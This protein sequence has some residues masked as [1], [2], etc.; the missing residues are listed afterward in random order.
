MAYGRMNSY[1]GVGRRG[2]GTG[3]TAASVM[4]DM[5][6]SS[7]VGRGGPAAATSSPLMMVG[8]RA[9]AR[10]ERRLGR[11]AAAL[12]K[13]AARATRGKMISRGI[14][15]GAVGLGLLGTIRNRSGPGADKMG[16][17]RPTGFYG[18]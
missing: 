15:G 4:R 14:V 1:R 6:L 12:E 13:A 2:A 7:A 5:G 11:N 16:S 8:M 17:Q 18:F 9:G 10:Q 3:G